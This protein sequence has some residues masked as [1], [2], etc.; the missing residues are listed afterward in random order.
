M[1]SRS[2]A[3]PSVTKNHT[4]PPGHRTQPGPALAPAPP[5]VLEPGPELVPVPAPWLPSALRRLSSG[6]QLPSRLAPRPLSPP[7]AVW[8]ARLL[9]VALAPP[10]G[11]DR[12]MVMGLTQESNS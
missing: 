7:F 10:A 12:T 5:H 9:H 11:R 3:G 1:A 6:Q 4:E 8:R 2:P